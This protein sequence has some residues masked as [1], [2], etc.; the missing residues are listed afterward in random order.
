V[1]QDIDIYWGAYVGTPDEILVSGK[2]KDVVD[3]IERIRA[4]A[5]RANGW[6]MDSYIVRKGSGGDG[7]HRANGVINS[8]TSAWHGLPLAA[9][10]TVKGPADTVPAAASAMAEPLWCRRSAKPMNYSSSPVTNRIVPGLDWRRATWLAI[11][12]AASVAFS[13]GFACAVPFAALGAVAALTLPRQ[14]AWLVLGATWFANQVVGF[15]ALGYPWTANAIAWGVALGV[16]AFLTTVAS[17]WCIR[18]VEAY[19]AFIVVPIAFFG[20]FAAYE[21]G[22][23]VIAAALLGGT[24]DF[25]VSIVSRIL[26]INVAAFAGLLMLSQLGISTGFVARCPFL[27]W[28]G[29]QRA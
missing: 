21:G 12:I 17:Q 13:F 29:T 2:L 8:D 7:C 6:I 25:T 23:F 28:A 18:R 27:P 14:H 4:E 15:A 10:A 1:D 26:E 16:I 9:E 5:R 20:A 22:C 11:L 19:G 24:E 3:D